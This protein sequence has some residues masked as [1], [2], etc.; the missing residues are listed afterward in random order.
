[1]GWE[2]IL[3]KRVVRYCGV[4]LALL[5]FSGIA[6]AEVIRD[7]YS[8]EVPV[9][10]QSSAELA[11]ASRLGLSVVLVK[12]SGSME[13]LGN[14]VVREALGGGRNRLQRYA[15]NGD[16]GSPGSL[17]VTMLFDSAYITRLVIDAGLPLWTANRP[18]VLLWLVE[19]G[20]G[21]RQFVNV[22]TEPAQVTTLRGEFSRRGVPVQ[23]PLYD[24]SDTAALGPNQAWDL[25]SAALL[26]ASARYNLENVLA[27]RFA[28]LA[29]GQVAGEWVYLWQDQRLKRSVTAENEKLFLREGVALVAE[30]MAARYAM[31]ATANEGGLTLSVTG[32]T[33][34]ADY[35]AIVAWMEGLE[36]VERANIEQVEGDVI[37]LRLQAQADAAQLAT[38]IELNKRLIPIPVVIPGAVPTADLNYQWQK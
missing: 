20:D 26:Q 9:A 31:A 35:A 23:L 4:T 3:N 2:K 32:V 6:R 19:E 8:A 29:T 22:E 17:L 24:L 18:M 13:V 37:L 36:L 14:P 1:L 11:R 7:M 16:P 28:Q 38:I 10:D 12:V 34:Y 21:G 27:G 15:Y 25:N 5:L 30:A 33:G